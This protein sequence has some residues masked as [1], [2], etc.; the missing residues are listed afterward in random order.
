M[1]LS[2][3]KLKIA[4]G[5]LRHHTI[6]RH[7]VV[8]PINI[9][10]IASYAIS[11][12]RDKIDVRLYED[13]EVIMKDIISWKP[14]VI[15]LSNYCW[16]ANLSALIF[17]YAKTNLKK[18]ICIS[19]GPEFP[20]DSQECNEYLKE[21]KEIDFYTTRE[22][23][24]AFKKIIEKVL[25]GKDINEL[26]SSPQDGVMSIN[27]HTD[28]LVIGP[29]IQRIN[30]DE[31]PS[32]YLTG[33]LD[34]F[35]DGRFSPALETSR[36]CPFT[37]GYCWGSQQ[38][39]CKISSF[40]INRV[41]AEIKY[42]TEKIHRYSSIAL[43]LADANFGM[44]DRDEEIARYIREM[45]DSYGWPNVFEVNTGRTNHDRILYIAEILQN[46]MRVGCSVQSLN[47]ETLEIIKRKNIPLGEYSRVQ[48][49]LK[50][51]GMGSIA[52]LIVP[53]P[54]ET[55]QSFFDGIKTLSDCG[56][57]FIIPYTTM[58]LKGT[59][60][61]S[62]ESREKYK[63][64][65][66]FRII[67][68]Q[69]GEY[70]GK[71]CF[72]VEEVC[73]ST[74]TLS[75]EDYLECRGIAFIMAL[76]TSEQFD[77]IR[78]LVLESGINMFEYYLYLYNQ[79]KLEKTELS[80]LYLDY[81]QETKEEL[82]DSKEGL[83]EYFKKEE[84]YRKLVNGDLGNNLIRKY[85]TKL[86]LYHTKDSIELCF[87]AII[88]LAKIQNNSE[89]KNALNA[90]KR[91][92]IATRDF[93][94]ILQDEEYREQKEVLTIDYDVDKWYCENKESKNILAYKNQVRYIIFTDKKDFDNIIRDANNLYGKN[95]QYMMEKTFQTL[96]FKD[97]WRQVEV[98][99]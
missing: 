49:E 63:L 23:E 70:D 6:G 36:G 10:F 27:P 21:R 18:V 24:I 51:R 17:N 5:D 9:G 38:W 98:L 77:S 39:Y 73:I 40:D 80:R 60:L 96:S 7:S 29:D 75:F 82:W 74:N 79:I 2:S 1:E 47:P 8:I 62:K 92:M 68:N 31:I 55:K 32:P 91:W 12:F 4:L 3:K 15:G 71:K 72:E 97:L 25:E 53:L 88:E 26:K 69:F 45:Q 22:G 11:K 58:L 94:K 14:D 78:R 19:G 54:K 65:Q 44:Y 20:E 48:T 50:K 85:K 95:F 84:N 33:L 34:Q 93:E 67:P 86:L 42:I 87:D 99:I 28:E 61:A 57:E 76:F 41:K 83:Y 37:C 35:L 59:P 43:S 30:L 90:V 52:E 89:L 16:N 81:I 56:V 64:S 66:K 13:P 46:K